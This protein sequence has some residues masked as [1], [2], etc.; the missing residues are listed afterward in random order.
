MKLVIDISEEDYNFVKKQV[1]DGITNPLKM[2]I[3]NGTPLPKGHG[4]LIDA[5]SIKDSENLIKRSD[6]I[7]AIINHCENDCYFRVDNWCPQCQREEFEEAIKAVPSADRPQGEWINQHENGHGFWVGV[8]SQCGK[9]KRVD[10]YCPNC[11]CKRPEV[12]D[13]SNCHS[14][15][16]SEVC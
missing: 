4:R 9:E 16:E 11:G 3:A 14:R 10:N 6:A 5:D 13:E 2:R 12:E 1:A 8:C 15:G 7:G